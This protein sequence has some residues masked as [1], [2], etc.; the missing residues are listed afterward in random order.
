MKTIRAQAVS[1]VSAAVLAA[2][3]ELAGDLQNYTA[4]ADDY[5]AALDQL[6]QLFDKQAADHPLRAEYLH[7]LAM[8]LV[9]E[10]KP[11]EAKPLL[12]ESLA[13]DCRFLLADHPSTLSVMEDLATVLEKTGSKQEAEKL[14]TQLKQLRTQPPITP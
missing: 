1:P 4:A 13:I 5:H 3:G 11:S 10:E 8:L 9:H 2:Q 6:A 12:E 7:A 14:R